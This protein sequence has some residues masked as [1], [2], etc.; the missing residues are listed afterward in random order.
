MKTPSLLLLSF[1]ITLGSAGVSHASDSNT[2]EELAEKMLDAIGGREVWANLRNTINGSQQNRAG[3][4]TEVYAVITMDFEQP[5]FRIET[6]APGLHLARV[7]NGEGSWRQ[8]RD[9]TIIDMVEDYFENEM[10]WYASHL[11]RT[12]HRVAARDPALSLSVNEK[13]QLEVYADEERIKWFQLD[14]DGVPYRFGSFD[15]DVGAICGPWDFVQ[16]GI[17]HPTWTSNA[18]GTWRASIQALSTNV[19]LRDHLFARPQ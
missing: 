5:R 10:R 16:D 9:G 8:M 11:Y 15:D 2:A 14:A 19:P 17:H 18:E 7:T 4:P 12:I 13:G 6:T 3:H 1:L